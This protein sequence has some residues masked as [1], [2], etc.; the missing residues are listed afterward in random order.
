VPRRLVGALTARRD[1]AIGQQSKRGRRREGLKSTQ[2]CGSKHDGPQAVLVLFAAGAATFFTGGASSSSSSSSKS[3]SSSS[4]S[5]SSAW[6]V[7]ECACPRIRGGRTVVLVVFLVC[8]DHWLGSS[9][10]CARLDK[11]QRTHGLDNPG[12]VVRGCV[13]LVVVIVIIVIVVVVVVVVL[14]LESAKPKRVKSY[15]TKIKRTLGRHPRRR[16][17]PRRRPRARAPASRQPRRLR[18][19]SPAHNDRLGCRLGHFKKKCSMHAGLEGE[20]VVAAA[21]T[22]RQSTDRH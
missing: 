5:S 15:T 12:L 16:R 10:T 11:K 6:C 14:A 22:S 4:S 2:K 19:V 20:W 7:C 13:L 9:H 1:N 18:L 8:S 17:R 21:H 3:S